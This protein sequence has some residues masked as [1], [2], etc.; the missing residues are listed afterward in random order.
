MEDGLRRFYHSYLTNFA[1]FLSLSLG[2]LF[3]VTLH[4]LVRAG[5][6]VVVRRFAEAIAANVWWLAVLAI[7]VVLGMR[8]LYHWSDPAAL[9]HDP[10]LQGKQAYLNPVFFV[11]RLVVYFAVWGY[12]ARYFYKKSVEQDTSRNLML[13]VQ[14][15]RKSGLAMV[16]FALTTAFA[17]YDLLMSLD[18]YWYST[19]FGV[20]YFAG[21]VVGFFSLMPIVTHLVQR[22]GRLT[23]AITVEH[24]HDMGKLIFAFTTFWAYIAFSQ[25]M[26]IWY[27]SLPEETIWYLRRQ[28]GSWAGV[29]W[30]LLFGHFVVPFMG[31]LPRFVKRNPRMLV[32]PAAWM[33]VMHWMDIYWLVMPQMSPEGVPFSLMDLTCFLALGG[34]CATATI[35]RL[36]GRSLVPEGDPRLAESL[37][38][39]SV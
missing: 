5:W 15:E 31:L 38:F 2:A 34:L 39:E 19:M 37:V 14:M 35:R 8:H 1:Y 26:L 3:F 27:A 9:A 4:H 23:H 25:Y 11:I 22:S 33:L 12:L 6:S 36:A 10:I 29:S 17:S 16:L 21:S 24:Y 20:Y 32:V 30:L 18:P 13:T 7:P 28:T